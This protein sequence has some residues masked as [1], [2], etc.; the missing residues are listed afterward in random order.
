MKWIDILLITIAVAFFASLAF[1]DFPARSRFPITTGQEV[2]DYA[3]DIM[4]IPCD[5]PDMYISSSV[6]F[7]ERMKPD[8]FGYYGLR[9]TTI[10]DG[11]VRIVG[12]TT[13]AECVV[14]EERYPDGKPKSGTFLW[15]VRFDPNNGW[16]QQ[17]ICNWDLTDDC[18]TDENGEYIWINRGFKENPDYQKYLQLIS[19]PPEDRD[20]WAQKL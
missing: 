7:T 19:C 16:V 2:R 1:L 12:Y 14:V 15:R 20:C 17:A 9:A 18:P 10:I 3:L 8:E 4:E 11:K 13:F 6:E 5:G